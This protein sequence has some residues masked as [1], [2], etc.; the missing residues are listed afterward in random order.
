MVLHSPT[1]N[2]SE[3]WVYYKLEEPPEM[4][5]LD[6]ANYGMTLPTTNLEEGRVFM[7]FGGE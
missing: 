2:L 5:I 1:D 7:L 3:G 4:H 6:D